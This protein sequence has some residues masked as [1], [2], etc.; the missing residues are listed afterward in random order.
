MQQFK[1]LTNQM[2]IMMTCENYGRML[3]QE[4]DD[5]RVMTWENDD[6]GE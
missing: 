6:L 1:P 5:P 4:N 3:T 2:T